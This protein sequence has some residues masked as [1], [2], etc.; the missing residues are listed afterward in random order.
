MSPRAMDNAMLPNPG[1][2]L[3]RTFR[4]PWFV[5][6]LVVPV[7]VATI[8]FAMSVRAD[9]PLFDR[10]A[11]PEGA[12]AM[13]FHVI[14]DQIPVAGTIVVD[15][16]GDGRL[17]SLEPGRTYEIHLNHSMLLLAVFGRQTNLE[18]VRKQLEKS[19][20]QK[21]EFADC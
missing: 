3:L 7:I 9:D 2:L 21:V 1:A 16:R 15:K 13:G 4:R 12:A 6:R 19:L 10:D 17:T 18:A 20:R 5:A 14:F 11:L 8:V